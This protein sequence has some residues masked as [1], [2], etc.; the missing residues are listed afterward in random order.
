MDHPPIRYF[1]TAK[2]A[3]FA[4]GGATASYGVIGRMP[5]AETPA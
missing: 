1:I 5:A 4:L 3:E 2:Q